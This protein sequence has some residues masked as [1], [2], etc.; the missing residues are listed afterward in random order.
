MQLYIFSNYTKCKRLRCMNIFGVV[1]WL[2]KVIFLHFIYSKFYTYTKCY[3]NVYEM[4]YDIWYYKWKYFVLNKMYFCICC[5]RNIYV[6]CLLKYTYVL[7]LICNWNYIYI[8]TI[9]NVV[10][11]HP[12]YCKIV[13]AERNATCSNALL[14]Y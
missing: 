11:C 12:P 13:K 1:K 5:F 9:Y 7:I 8:Y 10:F 2:R 3:N 6:L 4:F 14:L